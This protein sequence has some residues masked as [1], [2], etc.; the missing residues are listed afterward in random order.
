MERPRSG[1]ERT[2]WCRRAHRPQR[3]DHATSRIGHETAPN[4]LSRLL[5]HRGFHLG[6]RLIAI[7]VGTP[8]TWAPPAVGEARGADRASNDADVSSIPLSFRTAGFP[9]YGWKDGVSDGAFQRVGQLKPAPGMRWPRPVHVVVIS[10]GREGDQTAGSLEVKAL[11]GRGD[12][13]QPASARE[14]EGD[15]ERTAQEDIA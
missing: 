15:V 7:A 10:S 1:T 12:L 5:P 11:W 3:A 6:A 13:D 4:P 14:A 8:I 2:P 9:Q